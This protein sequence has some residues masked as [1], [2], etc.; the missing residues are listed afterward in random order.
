VLDESGQIT[1]PVEGVDLRVT[2][3]N[4]A[5]GHSRTF[6]PEACYERLNLDVI[7][8]GDGTGFF[9]VNRN[10]AVLDP[11]QYRLG[12]TH[13]RNN[14]AVDPDGP[15]LSEAGNTGDERVTMIIPRD[16]NPAV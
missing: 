11:G 9:I 15:I 16:P 2:T 10:G 8:K 1:F 12:I 6:L 13:R 4:E 3:S 5:A 14:R 7:R